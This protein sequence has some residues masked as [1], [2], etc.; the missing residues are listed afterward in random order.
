MT[1]PAPS[2]PPSPA[3]VPRPTPSAERV[4]TVRRAADRW[5]AQLIDTGGRN[6]LLYYRPFKASTLEVSPNRAEVDEQALERVLNGRPTD[7]GSLLTG[8][9]DPTDLA[10]RARNMFRKARENLEER[11]IDTLFVG[12]GQATWDNDGPTPAAPVVL[13][14]VAL[15]PI[16]ASQNEF[17]LT[18]SGEPVVN[19]VLIHHLQTEHGIEFGEDGLST[20][21]LPE[22]LAFEAIAGMCANLAALCARVPG[23]SVDGDVY[24]LAN[25]AY[26]TMPMVVDLERSV[27]QLAA[28]DIIASLAG[29][30]GAQAA[31]RE[32][33]I[34]VDRH[35][36]DT[37]PPTDEFLVLDA[38][39]SQNWAI[40]T[41]LQ[42]E[43]IVIEGPPGTG[44]SQTIANLI[45][46]LVARQKRVL[47]VAEK[48]AAI[49]AVVKRLAAVGLEDLVLDLHGGVRSKRELA[50][51]LGRSLTNVG[52]VLEPNTG[53]LHSELVERRDALNHH[54]QAMHE[55]REPWD[56][57]GI[58]VA[59]PVDRSQ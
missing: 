57:N 38:D 1:P 2:P 24:V 27:E 19:P 3:E 18:A 50:Q 11:G 9:E 16:G 23:F 35:L 29:D 37:T 4:E 43:S 52:S 20:N 56:I 14:P 48:R 10:K 5:R 46:S 26:A 44:K 8:A 40:N 55:A 21:G 12:G 28:N 39:A 42:G 41:A 7:L 22:S 51:L 30:E 45:S 15:T 54:A 34:D 32:R 59:G 33:I 53:D 6:R 31:M 49:D 47:F 36:P 58:S 13:I 25:F 17:R